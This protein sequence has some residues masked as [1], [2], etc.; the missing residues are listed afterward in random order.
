MYSRKINIAFSVSAGFILGDHMAFTLAFDSKYA[1]PMAIGKL[2][3][4]IAA[5]VL[6]SVI[7]KGMKNKEEET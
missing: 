6:A 5:L 1:M 3:S 7:I 4:G 2:I